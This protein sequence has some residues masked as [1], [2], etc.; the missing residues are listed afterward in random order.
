MQSNLTELGMAFMLE[1][2]P[3]EASHEAKTRMWDFMGK[4]CTHAASVLDDDPDISMA[5]TT[6]SEEGRN[7]VP[8]MWPVYKTVRNHLSKIL[9][10]MTHM[11][12][13]K[14]RDRSELVKTNHTVAAQ[15][16]DDIIYMQ[17]SVSVR[18]T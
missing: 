7:R 17:S 4:H 9:P 2:I 13:T 15:E 14:M 3:H 1:M 18:D 12:I 16:G 5:E 11:Q 10:E 6:E 8:L